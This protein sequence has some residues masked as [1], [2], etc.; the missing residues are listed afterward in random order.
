MSDV[1]KCLSSQCGG[2]LATIPDADGNLQPREPTYQV[3]VPL[4]ATADE[5]APGATGFARI[6]VGSR[7][8]GS[9]IWRLVCQ[10]LRFEL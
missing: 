6:R 10:T 1:P 4:A 3:T 7:S 2:S 9:R 8:V 5:I